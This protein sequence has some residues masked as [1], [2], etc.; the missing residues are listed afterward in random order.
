MLSLIPFY[1]G[2]EIRGAF[3]TYNNWRQRGFQYNIQFSIFN[4]RIGL[5]GP[6]INDGLPVG[7]KKNGSHLN[8]FQFLPANDR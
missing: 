2:S 3:L 6:Q 5:D 8:T 4:W 1:P 7:S